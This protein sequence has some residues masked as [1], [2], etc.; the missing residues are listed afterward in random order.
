MTSEKKYQYKNYE[1]EKDFDLN[2]KMTLW[3]AT[4][5][6]E[7]LEKR[8]K[9]NKQLIIKVFHGNECFCSECTYTERELAH[10]KKINEQLKDLLLTM[11][12]NSITRCTMK[13]CKQEIDIR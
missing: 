8:N 13:E 4:P 5:K 11:K 7:F 3:T 6:K 9:L 12:V 2:G 1:I 10:N